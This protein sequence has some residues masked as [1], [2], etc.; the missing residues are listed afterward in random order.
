MADWF[1]HTMGT[2]G[3]GAHNEP[4]SHIYAQHVSPPSL[5]PLSFASARQ[6]AART[7]GTIHPPQATRHQPPVQ[8]RCSAETCPNTS[9]ACGSTVAS[10][11]AAT[12]WLARTRLTLNSTVISHG[13]PRTTT[14]PAFET[15]T[16]AA[17][18]LKQGSPRVVTSSSSSSFAS[19]RRPHDTIPSLHPPSATRQK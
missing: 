8:P 10:F 1:V 19:C 7:S 9:A 17:M 4:S 12:T 6:D 14:S 2:I 13:T 11:Q 16:Q 3:F 5:A 15:W 18:Q